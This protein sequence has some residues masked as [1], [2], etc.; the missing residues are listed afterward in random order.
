MRAGAS[1]IHW[2]AASADACTQEL[3][4]SLQPGQLV[5]RSDQLSLSKRQYVSFTINKQEYI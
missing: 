4:E 1:N 5:M 2:A 3:V